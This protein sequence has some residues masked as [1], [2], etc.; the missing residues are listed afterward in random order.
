[1]AWDSSKKES[2]AQSMSYQVFTMNLSNQQG[3]NHA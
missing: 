2:E 1:M 3:R